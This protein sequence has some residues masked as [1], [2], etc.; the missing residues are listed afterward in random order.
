MRRILLCFFICILTATSF[1]KIANGYYRVRNL[2]T[3]RYIYVLDNTGSINISTASADMGALKLWKGK[4]KALTDPATVIYAEY[5]YTGS[6]GDMYD[7]QAQGTGVHSIIG[8]YVNIYPYTSYGATNQYYVYAEGK[9]LTDPELSSRAFA[10]LG[11]TGTG[12]YRIWVADPIDLEDNYVAVNPTVSV[13]GKYYAPYYVSFAFSFPS[14]NMNAKYISKVVG[15]YAVMSDITTEIIPASTPVFIECS[16][17]VLTD[18]KLNVLK[19]SSTF[20]GTNLLKGVYFNYDE[21]QKSKDAQTEYDPKTMR[22]LG[23]TSEG[24]LGFVT[25]SIDY[26]PANQSYLVVPEGTAE[27]LTI[28]DEAEYL[29]GIDG[30]KVK[31]SSNTPV[32]NLKGQ[33]VLEDN[34]SMNTLPQGIYISGGKKIRIK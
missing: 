1:A 33:K 30:V 25:A 12:D 9:Y 34:G 8:Y 28:I 27:E 19:S 2:K 13:N 18:N 5:Q 31:N 3:D 21:R 11:T 6:Y 22:V 23:T 10:Y 26:L 7:L 4:E 16:T 32:Y 17:N 29:A 24:K 20:S 15:G 14:T